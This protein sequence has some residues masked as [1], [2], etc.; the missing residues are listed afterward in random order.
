MR[1]SFFFLPQTHSEELS[2]SVHQSFIHSTWQESIPQS[3]YSMK[4]DWQ[5][6]VKLMGNHCP[7]LMALRCLPIASH[8]QQFEEWVNKSDGNDK[9]TLM[10]NG[11]DLLRI[12]NQRRG[13]IVRLMD[14][15]AFVRVFNCYT[16]DERVGAG[17]PQKVNE[18]SEWLD[19]LISRER[20]CK[21]S[22]LSQL[23]NRDL[24]SFP[25][26]AINHLSLLIELSQDGPSIRNEGLGQHLN[27]WWL[28]IYLIIMV[29]DSKWCKQLLAKL[30]YQIN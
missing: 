2:F 5:I 30:N 7:F 13:F 10:W 19:R 24:F 22:L 20:W 21:T 17:T 27:R 25:S 16:H 1:S 11:K 28:T 23:R 29:L 8:L 15:K 14:S 26:P 12:P 6:V 3:D 18:L 4:I 9:W